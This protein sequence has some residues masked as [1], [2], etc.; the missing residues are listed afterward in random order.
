VPPFRLPSRGP[1]A[2]Y[3]SYEIKAP[4]ATHWS[5]ASCADVDCEAYRLGWKTL[6]DEQT[7]LGHRQAALIRRNERRRKFTEE[8]DEAGLTV[9][10][11]E[12]GQTCFAEHKARNMRPERY[13]ERGGDHRGNPRR[14]HTVHTR[15]DDWV[16]SF[17][18]NQ[19]RL[20]TAIERG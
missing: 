5:V 1:A 19:D 2:A 9:F 16:D 14:E 18:T 13:V 11:F 7:N 17:Q 6:I 3:K 8:R 20:R 15:A 10:T 4:L 12:A